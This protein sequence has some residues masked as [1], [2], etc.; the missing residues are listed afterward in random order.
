MWIDLIRGHLT[1]I[2]G[3]RD[4]VILFSLFKHNPASSDGIQAHNEHMIINNYQIIEKVKLV[5][6]CMINALL[7]FSNNQVDVCLINKLDHE[8]LC[9]LQLFDFV[10]SGCTAI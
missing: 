8:M 7:S 1:L 5:F 3:L 9:I 2:P 4:L 6:V 10:G